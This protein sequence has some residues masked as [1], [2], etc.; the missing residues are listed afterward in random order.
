MVCRISRSFF[1]LVLSPALALAQQSPA[2][3]DGYHEF[4]YGEKKGGEQWV[5]AI[6]IVEPAPRAEVKGE[7]TVKFRAPGMKRARA[8]CW[9]Q[10]SGEKPSPW[11]HDAELTPGGIALDGEGNGS[12]V[13]PADDFPNGPVNI[14]VQAQND[15]PKYD[16]YELQLFNL[17]GVKWNQGIPKADPPAAKGLKLVFS[18]DFNGPL[19]LA[20]DGR[21]ARYGVH[22]PGG[23]DFSG[24]QFSNVLKDGQPFGQTGTWLK[25]AARKDEQSPKGRSGIIASVDQDFKGFWAKAPAYFE[26]RFTAQAAPGTWPAF[27]TMAPSALGSDELDI[28]EAYGGVGKGH[29]NHPGYSVVSHFW[30]QKNADGS[31]RKGVNAVAKIMELGGKSYW[32]TTF[33]TY[34]VLIGMKETVYYFDDIEVLRHPT[35]RVSR[36]FPHYFLVNYAIG[37]ISRWPIDLKRYNEG[38]DMWVDYVRVYA[39]EPVDPAYRPDL[40]RRAQLPTAGVGLNFSVAGDSSTE[41]APGEIA[42]APGLIQGHWNNLPGANGTER[43]LIDDRGRPVPALTA[44]WSVPPGD[45]AWRSKAGQDWGFKN[46]NWK[47]QKGYI[48]VG[49]KL[50]VSGIPYPKYHVHV[51][52]GADSNSGKGSVTISSGNGGGGEG[53]DPKRTYS[54]NLHWLEGR[55]V[56]SNSVGKKSPANGNYLIFRGNTAKDFTLDWEGD[57]DG[58]WTGVTGIQIVA[59]P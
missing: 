57:L 32:S 1:W 33:H 24:W 8:L 36:E 5:Q 22:K 34:A 25:I 29:P 40:M 30:S 45:T 11:G 56:K 12:F 9:Q 7:V 18:D 19:S 52:L 10:P 31:D 50:Q 41:L 44:K 26:C 15:E 37:G 53:V 4:N 6:A 16:V 58:A 23:G 27:W 2:P 21:G 17:G 42:G 55:F 20:N 46:E 49:G 35:N 3:V 54:Y 43:K 48:Q 59:E 14:R 39:Q 51:F 28:V 47:L 13:F 38:S